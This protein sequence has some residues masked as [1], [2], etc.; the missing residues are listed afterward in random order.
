MKITANLRA[1]YSTVIVGAGPAGATLARRLASKEENVLLIDGGALRGEK[2]CAGLLSPDAQDLLARY[3][4]TLPRE[5]LSSP[6]IFSVRTI[7]LALSQTR[8]YRR[9]YINVDRA[10]FDSFLLSLV[11]DTID[12]VHALCLRAERKEN[13][14]SLVLRTDKGE[15]TIF[16]DRLVGA[17]GAS[18]VVRKSLFPNEKIKRYVAIQQSFAAENE[19]PY[20]SCVF[21]SSTSPSCSW[22]FFK[23]GTLVFG[24]AFENQNPRAA[25]EE[26][27]RKLVSNGIVSEKIFRNPIKTQ[28]CTVLR[29]KISGGIFL[30]ANGAFL[31]GE[32]A[33]FISPSSLEGISYALASA[34]A[35]FAAFSRGENAHQAL[36]IY[37]RKTLKLRLKI[38]AKCVKRPFMYQPL[39]RRL[40]LGCGVGSIKIK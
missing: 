32:A 15:K 25:F 24:G 21:D 18:S 5:V 35:L 37:K 13:G 14:F 28:A 29:P 31:I 3:D 23:D 16:C 19:E 12:V 26:Q 34:E 10:K 17:D 22:I 1:H 9:N 38:S 33:G 39:L 40:I 30:G 20:Y 8:H 2:V 7:D 27:K 4:I 36:R 11:P 6:Q